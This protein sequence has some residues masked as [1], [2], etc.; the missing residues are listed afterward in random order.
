MHGYASTS[1]A[2]FSLN[3]GR[4]VVRY[5]DLLQ[6]EGEAELPR[7]KS[8]RWWFSKNLL[9]RKIVVFHEV[10]GIEAPCGLNYDSRFRFQPREDPSEMKINGREPNLVDADVRFEFY[11]TVFPCS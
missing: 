8:E 4:Q 11:S 5:S 1:Q 3:V 7:R 6:G 2:A 10:C 9:L